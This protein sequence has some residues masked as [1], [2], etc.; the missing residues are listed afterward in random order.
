MYNMYTMKINLPLPKKNRIIP[1][2]H[3]GLDHES[4]FPPSAILDMFQ[5][6]HIIVIDILN[7][8]SG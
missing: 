4:P 2:G 5:N 3:S 8:G 1:H 6:P 7:R